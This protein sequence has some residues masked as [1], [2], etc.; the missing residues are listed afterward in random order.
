MVGAKS[1]GEDLS[2]FQG[3]KGCLRDLFAPLDE[4]IDVIAS[5]GKLCVEEQ[6]DL[7][8]TDRPN[9]PKTVCSLQ[10]LVTRLSAAAG[11]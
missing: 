10:I 7:E 1:L 8:K 4:F 9:L 2:C 5:K 3:K 11:P 6:L